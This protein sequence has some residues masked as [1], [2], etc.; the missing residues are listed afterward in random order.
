MG[1]VVV[2]P[3]AGQRAHGRDLRDLGRD[4]QPGAVALGL[5][6]PGVHGRAPV[7]HERVD[8]VQALGRGGGE[9]AG[10]PF[11]ELVERAEGAGHDDEAAARAQARGE[12]AQHARRREVAG[13]GH[14]VDLVGWVGLRAHARRGVGE[15]DVDRAELRR[16]RGDGV[17][18][19]D[20]E[21]APLHAGGGRAVG[22]GSGGGPHAVGIAA[23][24]QDAVG[25]T[26]PSGERFDERA[27]EPLVG[28]RDEGGAR[29]GHADQASGE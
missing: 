27:A 12:R 1:Q 5:G 6:A 22:D 2:A 7:G 8:G 28:P 20:V 14:G 18:V 11:V 9:A 17:R 10:G 24:E 29:S 21:H 23:G 4:V 3:L 15:D 13:R 26:Q 25:R 16:Q 19:A